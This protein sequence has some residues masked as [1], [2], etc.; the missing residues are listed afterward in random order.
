MSES[1]DELF[2]VFQWE[3]ASMLLDVALKL[4]K[5]G[6]TEMANDIRMRTGQLLASLVTERVKRTTPE[7]LRPDS[8]DHRD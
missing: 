4:A 3:A 8:Y 7:E 5:M 6:H 2:S 1:D